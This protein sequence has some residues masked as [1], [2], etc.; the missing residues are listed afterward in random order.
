MLGVV[1]L[2]LLWLLV[3]FL[4]RRR[5]GLQVALN[6]I[7]FDRLHNLVIPNGDDGEILID[8]LLLTPQ[9]LLVLE[10]KDVRGVVFGS[11]KMQDWT[12]IGDERRYTFPNPQHGL[13]DRIAAVR[14]IVWQVPVSGR[15]LFLDGAEFRKGTPGLVTTIDQLV[16][17]F[18]EPDRKNAEV[19]VEAFQ[20]QWA[21]IR[22]Q[23][24]SV[25][26]R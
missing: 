10:I 7:A 16:E 22:S 11:D 13:Y 26:A 3:R 2:L 6:E 8:H 19:K 9:G 14:E 21:K 23:A 15:I 18:G 20:P 12:V 5:S 4:Q 25:A 24:S 17:E 1:A